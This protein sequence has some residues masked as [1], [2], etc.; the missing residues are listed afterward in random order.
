MCCQEEPAC[1][2][3]EGP[4][5]QERT[6]E[7]IRERH[8]G[9]TEQPCEQRATVPAAEQAGGA[10][11]GQM[12][13]RAPVLLAV[14]AHPDDEVFRC[15]GTLAL[16]ARRGVEVHLLTA[17][18]GEAGSRGDPPLCAPEEL[19]ALRERELRCACAAL[20]IEPP[21]LLEYR[22]GALAGVDEDEAVGQ[23][24][25]AIVELLPQALLTWPPGGL[26]GHADH[27][28]VSRWTARAFERAAALGA[29]APAAVYYPAVPRS[30]ARALGLAHLQAV[31]D[32]EVTLAVDVMPVWALKMAAI[33]CHR[34]QAGESPILQ[35]PAERQRLFLGREH[36]CRAQARRPHDVL[37]DLRE[38]R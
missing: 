26:S 19:P 21:R 12:A 5:R 3:G 14:L 18:R 25:A 13:D 17:T 37:L 4:G 22:D 11:R 32:N 33:G 34:T 31:P 30:V 7:Q 8:G 36:F 2:C 29:E 35:A 1:P 27:V 38:E 15:G 9:G 6:P 16:L 10:R 24:L 23:V 28:A 20:G